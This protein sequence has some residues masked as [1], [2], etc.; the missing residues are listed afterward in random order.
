[1][2]SQSLDYFAADRALFGDDHQLA[3]EFSDLRTLRGRADSRGQPMDPA[4]GDE[5]VMRLLAT[6]AAVPGRTS[7]Q[8]FIVFLSSS[9]HPYSWGPHFVPRYSPYAS[10]VSVREMSTPPSEVELVRNRYRNAVAFVDSLIAGFDAQLGGRGENDKAIEIVTGD[11]GEEFYERGHLAHAS[12]LNRYQ[13][14]VPII[15]DLPAS[16]HSG[17]RMPVPVASHIDIF[18]TLFDVL[19]EWPQLGQ[20]V[21]GRSLLREGADFAVSARCSSFAP[22]QILISNG[23]EKALVD[24]NGVVALQQQMYADDL[25]IADVRDAYDQSL[26]ADAGANEWTPG[27]ISG[28][29]G[30]AFSRMWSTPPDG[31]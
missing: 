26:V 18:P 14:E 22:R 27:K 13:T 19:G 9:H 7:G 17:P 3:D 15:F 2:A 31:R 11:H 12:E 16:L 5:E 24:L 30:D 4:S 29:F 23:R 20:V 28:V 1:M 6:D 25:Q 21:Q 10:L 8:L